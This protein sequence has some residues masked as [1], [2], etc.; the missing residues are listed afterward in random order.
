MRS[1]TIAVLTTHLFQNDGCS[2]PGKHSRAKAAIAAIDAVIS[3][4]GTSARAKL[5]R[6]SKMTDST[7]MNATSEVR[8]TDV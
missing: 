1:Q 3:L 5:P 8:R 2:G 6:R 7:D 4:T